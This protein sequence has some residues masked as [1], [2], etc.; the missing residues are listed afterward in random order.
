MIS[1]HPEYATSEWS[2]YRYIK[3]GGDAFIEEFLVKFSSRE[4][5][6]DFRDRKAITPIPGF[7]NAA[8]TDIRNSIYQRMCDITRKGGSKSFHDTVAGL[9]NGIDLKGA[10][11]NYFIGRE[12]LPELLFMGKVGVYVDMPV[13]GME[14]KQ[15]AENKHAYVYIYTAEDIINW[16]YE[17]TLNGNVSFSRLLLRETYNEYDELGLPKEVKTRY[18]LMIKE[19]DNDVVVKYLDEEGKEYAEDILYGIKEIRFVL[20]ELDRPLTKD[21]ANH[22]IALLNLESSDISY[23]LKANLVFYTEQYS[24]KFAS[25]HLKDNPDDNE[26]DE[27][28]IGSIQGR[29]YAKGMDRPA[30]IHP[31]SEP[32]I[33]SMAKQDKLKE[34]IRS[35]INLALSSVRPKFASAEAKQF[36][37]RGLESGLSFLGLVLERGEQQIANYFHQ[38]ENDTEVTTINYPERYGLKT[39]LQRME[40][41]KRLDDLTSVVP[42]KLYQKEVSKEI[43]RILLGSKVSVEALDAMIQEVEDAKY[44]T[45]DPETIHLDVEKGIVSLETAAQAR[46]YD[47]DEPKKAEKDHAK[48]LKRIEDAQTHDTNPDTIVNNDAARAEKQSSQDPDK[49]E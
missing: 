27:V 46:G 21:V 20:F 45:S 11:M 34:D 41:A 7:A 9:R 38:Y 32:L 47:D 6:D 8:L 39:D 19:G 26:G 36:D 18:R 13:I 10:T 12:V 23:T 29:R 31:S 17:T 33:A 22:Q 3:D 30:F 35:L 43:I 49:K 1:A 48:R 5:N 24:G 42:S 16:V 2:K 25:Q 14:T 37:E 40:E 15:E 4:S 44:M 28:E